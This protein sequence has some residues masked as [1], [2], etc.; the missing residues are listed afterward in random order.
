MSTSDQL[1]IAQK[2]LLG[3]LLH[4][5]GPNSPTQQELPAGILDTTVQGEHAFWYVNNPDGS[6]RWL[7]PQQAKK[8]LFLSL[9]NASSLKA[10]LYRQGVKLAF[11]A[12]K[13]EAIASGSLS[14]SSELSWELPEVLRDLAGEDY[15]IFTG[16]AGAL[17]KTV[18]VMGKGERPDRFMKVAHTAG[19]VSLIQ[20]ERNMLQALANYPWN[21]MVL[22]TA[23]DSPLPNAILLSNIRPANPQPAA[24]LKLVHIKALFELWTRQKAQNLATTSWYHDMVKDLNGLSASCD[25]GLDAA[26]LARVI[27]TLRFWLPDFTP[28]AL[29]STTLSHGDFTPWNMYLSGNRLF[30]YDWELSSWDRPLY[31]DFFHFIYQTEIL[32]HR[33]A[34]AAIW[35]RIQKEAALSLGPDWEKMHRL[36]L[37]ITL[38][39][40][41]KGYAAQKEVL[42]QAHWMLNTWATILPTL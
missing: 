14:L 20:N 9:Y 5:L 40:T 27:N 11:L 19:A 37:L 33:T 25:N 22:P 6:I 30:L 12:G 41:L 35:A 39:Q 18:V 10:K 17:R 3:T 31:Y 38:T 4:G 2:R 42:R 36:Y 23:D 26:Q 1:P 8:P 16:T 34:P 21:H 15:A 28:Q 29:V 13:P 7:F 24:R 32:V